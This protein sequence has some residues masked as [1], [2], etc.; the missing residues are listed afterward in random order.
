MSR[1]GKTIKIICI[2]FF[3]LGIVLGMAG[4]DLC[5]RS[6]DHYE[7][8]QPE[9]FVPNEIDCVLSYEGS[10]QIYVCYNDAS[11]VNVY[12]KKGEFLWAVSTPYLR[13][14]YFEL[15]S[16]QLVIYGNS[17]IAYIYNA[18]NGNF[19]RKDNVDNLDLKYDWEYKF[20]P[21]YADGFEEGEIYYDTY[22]VY[23]ADG[24]G[25]LNVIVSRPW[26]YWIFNFAVDWCVSFIGA[27]V[28]GIIFIVES[29]RKY[30]STVKNKNEKA[31][32]RNK[33][34]VFIV[35]YDKIKTV[36]HF[37]YTASDILCGL[38][39]GGILCIGIIPIGIHFIISNIIIFNISDN[40]N[41]S[42]DERTIVDYWTTLD[43]AS[44]VVAFISVF[45]AVALAT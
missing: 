41:V 9:L 32:L 16:G 39:L 6:N 2:V 30:K 7:K 45:I 12:S 33:K 3:V 25:N 11:Y 10:R 40:L 28:F 1:A 26:W 8:L 22:Q 14:V 4:R 29:F 44:F 21:E 31:A 5:I 20:T 36:I 34:A 18:E 27:I 42:V 15:S 17:D 38:F 19:I 23:A 43:F 24:D 37:A 13:N 35:K